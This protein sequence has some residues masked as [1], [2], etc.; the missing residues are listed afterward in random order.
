M[1]K[2]FKRAFWAACACLVSLV[3]MAATATD[4]GLVKDIYVNASGAVAVTLDTGYPNA[5][6]AAV[7][8]TSNG[9][10]GIIDPAL[11]KDIKAALMLAKATGS[12]VTVAT[13][14]CENAGNWYKI[15]AVYVR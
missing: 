14:G 1:N 13:N 7:C 6:A 5:A 8:S 3:A 12:K 4:T 10:A 15:T 11:N 9:Y 2:V